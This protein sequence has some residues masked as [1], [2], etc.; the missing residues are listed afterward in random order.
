[1]I[2]GDNDIAIYDM[3]W[4]DSNVNRK[5]NLWLPYENKHRW[6]IRVLLSAQKLIS[7]DLKILC[8]YMA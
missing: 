8:R 4:Y 5:F 2:I 3:T 7:V 6:C 1:M